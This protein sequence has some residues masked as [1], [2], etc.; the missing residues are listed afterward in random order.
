M[1]PECDLYVPTP[2]ELFDAVKD[3]SYVLALAALVSVD[4]DFTS[5]YFSLVELQA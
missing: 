4:L 3:F 5:P 2:L 1:H